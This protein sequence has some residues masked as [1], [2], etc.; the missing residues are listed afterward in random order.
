MQQ[1]SAFSGLRSSRDLLFAFDASLKTFHHKIKGKKTD[2]SQ[3]LFCV[4]ER[5]M[6]KTGIIFDS[7]AAFYQ[8]QS[9]SINSQPLFEPKTA[10][11]M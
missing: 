2:P 5:K 9:I 11:K 3:G 6:Q 4:F 7:A 8:F 1:P 10:P